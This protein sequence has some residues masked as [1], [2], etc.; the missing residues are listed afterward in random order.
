MH[1]KKDVVTYGQNFYFGVLQEIWVLD[2]HTKRI[3]VFMCQ[4]VDRKHVKHDNLGYTS[5]DLN[6]FGH[7]DD[8]FILASQARQVFYVRDQLDR[9]NHV[10]LMT[11]PKNYR[12]SYD[13]VNEDFSTVTFPHE[14]NTL[15]PV[16][17]N[18]LLRNESPDDYWRPG[19]KTTTIR[20]GD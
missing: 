11:P 12:H 6:K 16:Q 3:P 13:E 18:Q 17:P 20:N 19:N 14:G 9:K 2:Y 10:V 7:K 1:I 15:P 4:W 5:V 8:P